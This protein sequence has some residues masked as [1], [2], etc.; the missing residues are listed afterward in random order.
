MKKVFGIGEKLADES[1]WGK[2]WRPCLF[3]KLAGGTPA[4]QFCGGSGAQL[5][6]LAAHKAATTG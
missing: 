6:S 2:R 3:V 5:A 1:L 4:L